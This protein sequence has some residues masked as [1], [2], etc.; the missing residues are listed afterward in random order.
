MPRFT[1]IAR[2]VRE[3]AHREEDVE[4]AREG[5]ERKARPVVGVELE[6]ARRRDDRAER[7]AGHRG[8]EVPR[9]PDGPLAS[10]RR[11]RHD[12]ALDVERERVEAPAAGSPEAQGGERAAEVEP[13]V[14]VRGHVPGDHPDILRMRRV[15]ETRDAIRPVHVDRPAVVRGLEEERPHAVLR[16]PRHLALGIHPQGRVVQVDPRGETL[17][18]RE[19]ARGRRPARTGGARAR[20]DDGECERRADQRTP[21]ARSQCGDTPKRR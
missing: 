16:H 18:G 8:A 5:C 15:H 11:R 1:R 17:V 21:S 4:R 14:L 9:E 12:L 3:V 6:P 7:E 2:S 10:E 19:I 20:G 13:E